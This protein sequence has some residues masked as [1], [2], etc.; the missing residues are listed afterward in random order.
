MAKAIMAA[1]RQ[2]RKCGNGVKAIGG[3]CGDNGGGI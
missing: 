1:W 3:V 2:W